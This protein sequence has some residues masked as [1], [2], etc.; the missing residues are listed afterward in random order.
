MRLFENA[1]YR[2]IPKRKIAFIC[3]LTIIVLGMIPL[4]TRGIETGIDF[5]GG[6]EFVVGTTSEL[7]VREVRAALGGALGA[8]PEVK[9]FDDDVLIRTTASGEPDILQ[10]T[11]LSA[12]EST[13]P[14][15]SPEVLK[16]DVVGPRFADDLR[17]GAILAVFFSL[18]VIFIYIAV[19]FEWRFGV[20]AVAAVFHDVLIVLGLFAMLHHILPFSLQVDQAI[21]AAFLTIVGYS[22]N[23]TVVVFDRIREDLAAYKGEP[24]DV[25]MDRAI[26]RTLSRTVVTS[27]TTLIV[28]FVLFVFGGEVLRGFSFAL[29]VGI[30]VG[31][32]SSIFIASPVAYELRTRFAPKPAEPRKV[33]TASRA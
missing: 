17:D 20:G 23:D 13:F 16:R 31:T 15:S 21:I 10:Q 33:T 4:A 27:G 14:G 24:L 32:Y 9:R 28:V 7:D 26:S 3:S 11:V 19:R 8:E 18:L 12:I 30:I 29:M 25:V 22:I 1:D 2:F 6:T 5:L